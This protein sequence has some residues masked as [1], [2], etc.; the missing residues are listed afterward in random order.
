[1]ILWIFL[2]ILLAIMAG[3]IL[4]ALNLQSIIENFLLYVLFFW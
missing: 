1:M 2:L 3:F 4:L